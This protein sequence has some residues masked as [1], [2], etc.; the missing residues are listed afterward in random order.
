[1][2]IKRQKNY[3]KLPLYQNPKEE[4][5]MEELKGLG[6]KR[7]GG[8]ADDKHRFYKNS[9]GKVVRVD[10]KSGKEMNIIA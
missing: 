3:T 5:E 1:M 8:W 7:V 6:Y 9:D 4:A 2:I 10:K